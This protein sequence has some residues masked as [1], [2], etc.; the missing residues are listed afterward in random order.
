MVED[1][2]TIDIAQIVREHHHAV[3]GYAFRLT[4]SAA[5]AEDLTQH[6]FLVAHQKLGQLQSIDHAR[7]WLFAILRN[8]FLKSQRKRRPALAGNLDL[9]IESV[10][11]KLPSDDAI[12]QEALQSALDE[13]PEKFRIVL[14][15]FYFQDCSYRD[16]S[17]QLGVPMGTVMSRLARAKGHLRARLFPLSDANIQ[18]S[19]ESPASAEG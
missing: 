5:D 6:A 7:G 3:Y 10:P 4:G 15:M 17:D 12:D 11:E 2:A 18:P 13:L 8:A 16:I 14:M 19:H 1:R 9:K